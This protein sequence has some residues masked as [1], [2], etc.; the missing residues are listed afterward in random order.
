[1]PPR[2]NC[3]STWRVAYC[4]ITRYSSAQ[5]VGLGASA[6]KGRCILAG[7]SSF[8]D[9]LWVMTRSIM[10]TDRMCT[11]NGKEDQNTDVHGESSPRHDAPSNGTKLVPRGASQH[12]RTSNYLPLVSR[13]QCTPQVSDSGA[14]PVARLG[15]MLMEH[16]LF[17][18]HNML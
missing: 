11:S 4:V 13:E 7:C 17:R 9:V 16:H 6:A 15:I 12:R 1:M 3:G 10:T 8:L 5:L 18:S 2:G 14:W